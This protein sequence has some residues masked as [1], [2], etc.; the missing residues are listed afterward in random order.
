[1]IKI[2]IIVAAYNIENYIE[3]CINSLIN[4]TF[5]DI[6]IVVVNDGSTDTTASKIIDLA[7]KDSRIK[8]VNKKNEGLIEARRTGLENSTGDYLIFID[9]DDWLDLECCEKVYKKIEEHNC[10]VVNYTYY[11]AYENG[12]NIRYEITSKSLTETE[13]L[14]ELFLINITPCIWSKVI[15]RKF[16]EDNNITFPSKVTY[17]EDLAMAINIACNKPSVIT[18]NEPLYYYFQRNG[19][20]TNSKLTRQAL[21]IIKVLDYGKECMQDKGIYNLFVEEYE[22]LAYRNLFYSF[23]IGRNDINDVH[24]EIYIK[25]KDINKSLNDNKYIREHRKNIS[26]KEKIKMNLFDFNY[27]VG[28]LYIKLRNLLRK[29]N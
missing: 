4:Q 27:E 26:T 2:S 1:M 9:G 13:F 23:V 24:K 11:M 29:G 21:D 25:W 15:R 6:E 14:K 3:K 17:G 20:I 12:E 28:A 7:R 10:D 8:V 18:I 19:S 5:K 16:L 22:Y